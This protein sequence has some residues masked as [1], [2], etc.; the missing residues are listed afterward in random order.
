MDNLI[1]FRLQIYKYTL[2]ISIICEA[3]A[4]PFL[5]FT[6]RYVHYSYGLVLGTCVAIMSFNILFIVSQK[7]LAK[8]KRWLA[9]FGYMIR[10]P[11]YGAA[12]IFCLKASV[13][14]AV[15][16]LIGFMTVVAAMIYIHGIKAKFSVGRKVRPEVQAE[17]EREDRE[18]ELHKDDSL[19]SKIK[20]EIY[21][22][23]D[24]E[25]ADVQPIETRAAYSAGG[26]QQTGE[27]ASD[28][29]ET[30]KTG[31]AAE[32]HAGT[33]VKRT[34]PIKRIAANKNGKN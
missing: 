11:I 9:P 13:V 7:V 12:F 20:R 8:K 18:K 28:I 14:A 5:K 29:Y 24:D 21:Y 15:A 4:L 32:E 22:H 30:D 2:I 26:L 25:T 33:R 16:C 10:L 3:A 23:D 6:A 34:K 19:M 1:S 17:F 31:E 27:A